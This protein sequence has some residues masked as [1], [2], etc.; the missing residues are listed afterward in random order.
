MEE[1]HTALGFV[2]AAANAFIAYVLLIFGMSL[3]RASPNKTLV[4][5]LSIRRL[6]L[7]LGLLLATMGIFFGWIGLAWATVIPFDERIQAVGLTACAI[8]GIR[9]YGD[10]R[11][12]DADDPGS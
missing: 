8:M 10:W 4:Q 7:S 3:L 11:A 5:R 6:R 12:T 1:P 9:A 2:I